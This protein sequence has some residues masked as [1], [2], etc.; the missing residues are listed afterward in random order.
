MT[1]GELTASAFQRRLLSRQRVR[2]GVSV[3]FLCSHQ[4]AEALVPVM[5]GVVI[6]RAV[7]TSDTR[8]LLLSLA[9]LALLFT[10]L[11]FSYFFGARLGYAAVENESH[12]NR[13][14]IA[15]RALDPRGLRSGLRDGELLSITASDAE[16]SSLVIRAAGI[17]AAATTALVVSGIA[18]LVVDVPL[19]LGVLLGVPLVVFVLQRL[20]PLLT[21]RSE[22]QQEALA[23]T[24]AL[25]VDLVSGLRVLRGI[26]AQDHA[27]RRY[28]ASSAHALGVTLRAANSKGLHLGLTTAVNG[29]FLAAVAGTAGWMALEGRLT[30]GELVAV[31]GLAQFIAEPVGT[32]GW[33][34]QLFATAKASAGRVARVLGAAPLVTPGTAVLGDATDTRL[35]LDGVGYGSLDGVSMRVGAGEIVGVVAYDPS[36]AD[37]LVTLLSGRVP[38]DGY[39]GTVHIDG[40]AAETLDWDAA[41]RALLVEQHDVALFEGTLRTNLAPHSSPMSSERHAGRLD[42]DLLAALRA[43]GAEDVIEA[44][45]DGLDRELTERGANLSGGQRQRIGL[46]RALAAVPPVLVLHDPTTSVDAVTEGLVADGLTAARGTAPLGTLVITSSPALLRAAHRITVLDGGRVVAEGTHDALAAAD[47]RYREA[48][49][50]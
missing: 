47:A 27:A 5:I 10:V 33:C 6:D 26:G 37:A 43:A 41:R 15:G 49:L 7:A 46:A 35:A 39:R 23:G 12:H 30:V 50:R 2:I 25:A 29:L 22:A 24:T 32:L 16:I 11:T 13:V 48:V 31:V 42:H 17:A 44:H 38:R 36:D 4:A 34:V 9:G 19:G 3:A 21:R 28:A 1:A 20:A 18:L 40:V 14:E 45:P 8:A